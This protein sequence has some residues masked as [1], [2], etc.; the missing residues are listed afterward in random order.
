M[1]TEKLS[2]LERRVVRAEEQ[3]AAARREIGALQDRARRTFGR[4]GSFWA[5]AVFAVVGGCLAATIGAQGARKGVMVAPFE[6]TDAKGNAIFRVLASGSAGGL[7]EFFG[8]VV[9]RR[10]GGGLVASVSTIG[11]GNSNGGL[12]IYGA[13]TGAPTTTKI[14][15]TPIA[16]PVASL[17]S[18]EKGGGRLELSK[19][20]IVYVEAGI[21]GGY[22][23]VRALPQSGTTGGLGL[24]WAIEGRP[25]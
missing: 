7:S 20:G 19:D 1:S 11:L 18:G 8:S 23:V 21:P 2:D 9:F 13:P 17:G 10:S 3:V 14:G 25:K 15:S 4:I 22:G 24:P 6:V 16:I 12:V 5:G